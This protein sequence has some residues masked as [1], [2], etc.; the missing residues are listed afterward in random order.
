MKHL[1]NWNQ[2]NENYKLLQDG[3]VAISENQD[4]SGK[5]EY[6][7][8]SKLAGYIKYIYGD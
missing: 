4:G 2:L 6:V 8:I 1:K 5:I 7:S 3:Y